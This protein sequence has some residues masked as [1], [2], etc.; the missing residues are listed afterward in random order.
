VIR[1]AIPVLAGVLA[2]LPGCDR[3]SALADAAALQ[4]FESRC[5]GL[6]P[7]RID[8]VRVGNDVTLDRTL[9]YD[10]LARLAEPTLA[11]H[12]TVGLTRANFGYRT[13][14]ELDGLEDPRSGRACAHPRV[15][16]DIALT[17]MTI[18]VAREYQGDACREPL[19]LEHER[20]HVAVFERYAD[21]AAPAL[22]REIESR[23]GKRVRYGTTMASMQDAL[24]AELAAHLDAFMER[25]RAD[26]SARHAAV[27]TRREYDKLAQACGRMP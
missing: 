26:I 10:D 15:R 19:I 7:G 16:V 13:T 11:Q 21:E 8:V 5:Q 14:L 25:A 4:A 23:M 9:A 12:R 6:P 20:R 24:K 2:L 27:D 1:A 17:E 22:A 3:V 18:Y